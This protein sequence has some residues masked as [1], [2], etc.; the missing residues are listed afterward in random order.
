MAE[1]NC[2]LI[3]RVHAHI[4]VHCTRHRLRSDPQMQRGLNHFKTVLE[5]KIN[6]SNINAKQLKERVG[7]INGAEQWLLERG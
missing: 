7:I 4:E 3:S 2:G 1:A 6:Q 5:L